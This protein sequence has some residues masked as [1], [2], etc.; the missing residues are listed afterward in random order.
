MRD[1]NMYTELVCRYAGNND[2]VHPQSPAS[3][4][5]ICAAEEKLNVKFPEELKK[6]LSEMNGDKFLC[7][8]VSGIIENNLDLR[9]AYKDF[10]DLSNFLFVAENGCGDYYGY[11]IENGM[12]LSSPIYIWEH[13]SFKNK[14][15]ADNL[16]EMIKL[17]YQDK[18]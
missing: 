4:N 9:S 3:K 1:N 15:V 13:E 11:H 17:Y 12:V 14:A 7:L 6:L 10:V 5:E 2:F 8:S 18:I 16:E